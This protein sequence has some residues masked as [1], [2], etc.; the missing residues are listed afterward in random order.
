MSEVWHGLKW[1]SEI[2]PDA[3]SPM[4]DAGS[5]RHYYVNEL[6]ELQD[7]QLVIPIRWFLRRGEVHADAFLV[8][9]DS[10]V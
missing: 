3:L 6:A 1:R 2:D 9:I 10:E 7:G 8:T 5:G 4:W